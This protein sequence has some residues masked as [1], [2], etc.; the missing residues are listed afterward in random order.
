[1][2]AGGETL[3]AVEGALAAGDEADE[4]VRAVVELL[5]DRL[6]R[7]VRLRFVEPDGLVD[8]PAAG[9]P[10]A[11]TS[12][13]V[14]FQGSHV[15]ELEVGGEPSQEERTLLAQVAALLAQHALVAWDTDGEPWDP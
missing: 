9:D 5:H 2:T 3:A 6:G 10:A 12:F 7:Y 4:V 1:V 8:G 15:A 13:P 14:R 11:T